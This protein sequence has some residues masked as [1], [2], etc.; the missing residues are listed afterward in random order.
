M[1]QFRRVIKRRA[2]TLM[3]CALSMLMAFQIMV[4]SAWA[5]TNYYVNGATGNDS[6]D[7]LSPVFTSGTNGPKATI[8]AGI[9]VA[10]A[11]D[12]VN[13]AAG[14][15]IEQVVITTSLTLIGAGAV[16]TIIKAPATLPIASLVTSSIVDINGTGISVDIGGFTVSGPGPSGCGSIGAGIF[17]R[18]GAYANIHDNKILDIRDDPFSGCQNGIGIIVGRLFLAPVAR[19][20]SQ[21]ISF[22]AI[23]RAASW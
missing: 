12:I 2:L 19:R 6:Y 14:T 11:N 15:Y 4:G 20:I 21:T 5:Q 22:P 13:V 9:N 16:T 23:K 8:Q 3:L 18:G 17:V 1:Q 10:A 7:G